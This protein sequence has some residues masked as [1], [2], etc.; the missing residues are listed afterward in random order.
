MSRPRWK[1]VYELEGKVHTVSVR[2]EKTGRLFI[3]QMKRA[4]PGIDPYL[5]EE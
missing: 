5:V 1:I 4:N 3:E 2:D